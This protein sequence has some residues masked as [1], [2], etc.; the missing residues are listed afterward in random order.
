M[1]VRCRVR[2]FHAECRNCLGGLEHIGEKGIGYGQSYCVRSA[3]YGV[4][5]L[6][7]V[8]PPLV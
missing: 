4:F 2:G 8:I 6:N 7:A 3:G 1:D 5:L